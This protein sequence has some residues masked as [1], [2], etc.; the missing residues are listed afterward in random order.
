MAA[1][2]NDW[3]AQTVEPALEPELPICDPHHHLWD[4]RADRVEPRYML[5]ELMADTGSGHNIVSTVFVEAALHV[6]ARAGQPHAHRRRGGVRAGHRGPVRQ[7]DVRRH[8]RRPRHRR[9][10]Q[11]AP[12]SRRAPG[13]GGLAGGQPQPLQRHPPRRELGPSSR[14]AQSR[15][16]SPAQ[17]AGQ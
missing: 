5:D 15:R 13:A 4:G 7:R 2:I 1:P 3:L 14:S 17:P 16:V 9:P 10:R 11:P 8:P 6:P 12:G